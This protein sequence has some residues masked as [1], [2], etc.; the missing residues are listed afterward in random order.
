MLENN[1]LLTTLVEHFL[2]KALAEHTKGP[3]E[4]TPHPAELTKGPSDIKPRPAELTKGPSD[5]KPRPAKGW[6]AHIAFHRISLHFI[7]ILGKPSSWLL[8]ILVG[9]A[10]YQS[11]HQFIWTI[12]ES[13]RFIKRNT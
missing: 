2:Y 8:T 12:L 7:G 11:Y 13:N 1:T 5:I 9:S 3:S 4:I 10:N 6:F